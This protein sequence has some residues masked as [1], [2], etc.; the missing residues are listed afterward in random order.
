VQRAVC[1]VQCAVCSRRFGWPQCAADCSA[2]AAPLDCALRENNKVTNFP[3][4]QRRNVTLL[5]TRSARSAG[6]AQRH[7]QTGRCSRAVARSNKANSPLQHTAALW[8]LLA[9]DN[10]HRQLPAPKTPRRPASSAAQD[11]QEGRQWKRANMFVRRLCEPIRERLC[12]RPFAL[13][14]SAARTMGALS[15]RSDLSAPS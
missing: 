13:A 10:C 4:K 6:A 9:C 2:C 3:A 11:A 1:S 12:V 7:A 8:A 15:T 5:L 14:R